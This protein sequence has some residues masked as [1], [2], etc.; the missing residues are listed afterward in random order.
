M[1]DDTNVAKTI[2]HNSR[3]PDILKNEADIFEVSQVTPHSDDTKYLKIPYK[4]LNPYTENDTSIFFGRESDIQ[5]MVNNLLAWRLTILYGKSGV[6]KS[7]ILRAGV[8]HI[9]HEEAQQNR[10]DYDGIPKLAVVVFPSLERD[11]SWR[12]DPLASLIQQIEVTIAQRGWDIQPPESG[13]SFIETLSSWTD[14]LGGEDYDGELYLILDQFEE[15]FLYHANEKADGTFYTEFPRAVNCPSLRVNFLIST[16]KDSLAALDR[17][18]SLIPGLLE[19]RLEMG[20]LR[21]EAAEEAI[22]KPIDYY[23]RQYNTNISIEQSLVNAILEEVQVGKVI[24]GDSGLGGVEAKHKV[25]SEMQIETPYLQLV[26]ERLWKEEH[27]RESNLLRLETFKALG[28]ADQIVKDHL[29]HQMELLTEEE[30]Q[31]AASI[32]QYLVTLSG[33]K[34]ACSVFELATHT[35]CNSI[36]LKQ[37]LE[38][39]ASGKQRI[40]RPEGKAKSDQPDTQRYEIFHDALANPILDW[41]RRYLE[42]QKLEVEKAKLEEKRRQET[43]KLQIEVEQQRLE[44]DKQRLEIQR[45]QTKSEKK[46]GRALITTGLFALGIVGWLCSWLFIKDREIQ[47]NRLNLQGSKALVEFQLNTASELESVKS[48]MRLG[49]IAQEKNLAEEEVPSLSLSLQQILHRIRAKNQLT[50]TQGIPTR[51]GIAQ[52]ANGQWIALGTIDG[53]VYRRNLNILGWS[54]F[55]A[56]DNSVSNLDISDDGQRIATATTEGEVKVWDATTGQLIRDFTPDAVYEHLR[57]R[58]SPDGQKLVVISSSIPH[59]WEIDSGERLVIP[60]HNSR[61]IIQQIIFSP[62][63]QKMAMV[64]SNVEKIFSISLLDL[65]GNVINSWQVPSDILN[66]RFSPDSEQLVSSSGNSAT[67]WNLQGD[68]LTTFQGH[69]SSIRALA[70]S[71]DGKELATGAEDG[72]VRVWDLNGQE[73][74]SL[75]GHDSW[76]AAIRFGSDIRNF[77]TITN[78]GT[79]R[80]WD[81]TSKSCDSA[82]NLC[83]TFI[84]TYKF[85]GFRYQAEVVFSQDGHMATVSGNGTAYLWPPNQTKPSKPFM[86]GG[87]RT[88]RVKP[89]VFLSPD[90]KRLAT[91]ASD[92]TA[93]LWSTQNENSATQLFKGHSGEKAVAIALGMDRSLLV[94]ASEDGIFRLKD[95]RRNIIAEFSGYKGR[96]SQAIFSPNGKLIATVSGKNNI[97]QIWNLQGQLLNEFDGYSGAVSAIRFSP[98]SRKL[99]TAFLDGNVYLRNVRR[100]ERSLKPLFS[101]GSSILNIRFSA[102]GQKLA[103]ASFDGKAQIRSIQGE[104]LIEFQT[105]NGLWDVNFTSNGQRLAAVGWR[106]KGYLWQIEDLNQLLQKGCDWMRDYLETHPDEAKEF[107]FCNDL[108]VSR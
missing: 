86:G 25:L 107:V 67:L 105:L 47:I 9:L 106:E 88:F 70:F 43:E 76:I 32:F 91:I 65:R 18:K 26:M 82:E 55:K 81:V 37:L 99:A 104:K 98:D 28:Q 41:R 54:K 77:T 8:T 30:R 38:K 14:A 73:K 39:L 90:A 46:I 29:N 78:L 53:M 96:S 85:S 48:A 71:P 56:T 33:M 72:F 12:D 108:S 61:D 57:I 44:S 4:G 24:L 3:N 59:L 42:Q 40:V 22:T 45:Q 79:I 31:I 97:L 23:N 95:F 21:G 5:E 7:S 34:C 19:H 103:T 16:R 50:F 69:W 101:T 68:E 49:H 58:L 6:G 63:G 94:T 60:F 75:K 52:S 93:R 11:F 17:F 1:G 102:D 87:K 2:T 10:I 13:L 51:R 66:L 20:H 27:D 92:G 89:R 15:Y 62:D 64:S 35:R 80:L 84:N 100:K 74:F 83:T 36:R